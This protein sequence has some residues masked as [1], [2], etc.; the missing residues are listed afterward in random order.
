MSKH[1]RVC[2]VIVA[3]SIV[4]TATSAREWSDSQGTVAIDA[5]LIGF[6]DEN[7]VLQRKDKELGLLRIDD[8][9]NKDREYLKSKE[10]EEINENNIKK[11]QTWTTQ[12][13][14]KLVGRIVDY[15]QGDVTVQRRRGRMYVNDRVFANLPELYQELLPKV[16][17]HF[18]EIEIPDSRALQNWLRSLRG[19]PRTFQVDGVILEMENGD[20]YAIPFFVFSQKDRKIIKKG[21]REWL[22]V[23]DDPDQRDDRAFQLESL[24]AAYVKNQEINRQIAVMNLNLQAI[25]AGLTS[26]WEVTLYPAPGNPSP[27][28]WV[29]M[30][31]RDSAQAAAA[32]LANNPGFVVGSVRRVSRR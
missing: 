8:L 5:E 11:T 18:D 6:D 21:W 10:A 20:E 24:A 1:L 13:G 27:P 2:F 15:A 29:L 7:V 4:T 19:K 22:A 12:S 14:V 32:A 25:N 16:V 30:L 26:T 9:S 28:Q 17:E 31:G 23:Q 3:S